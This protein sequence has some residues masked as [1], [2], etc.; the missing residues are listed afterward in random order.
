[1]SRLSMKI[2]TRLMLSF[3]SICFLLLMIFV[4][5][6]AELSKL[7]ADMLLIVRDRWPKVDMAR[8]ILEQTNRTAIA[9]RNMLLVETKDERQKQLDSLLEARKVI[10][11]DI[12]KLESLIVRPKGKALLQ[13]MLQARTTYLA[14][15]DKIIAHIHQGQIAEA[16]AYLRN[17]LPPHLKR[18]KEALDNL[19]QFQV[20]LI[21]ASGRAADEAY[22]QARMLVLVLG[23]SAVVL[24]IVIGWWLAQA[25]TKPLGEAVRLVNSVAEGNLPDKI[26]IRSSDE[27]GRLMQALT[28]MRDSL[29]QVFTR[30]QEVSSDLRVSEASLAEA[31]HMVHLGSW[32]LDP[33]SGRMHWSAETC[34]IFGA[35]H[36][37]E[38]P[39]YENFL[40]R[41]HEHDRKRVR[42]GLEKSIASGNDFNAEHRIVQNHGAVRWVQTIARYGHGDH[43]RLL[44]G[45]IM[46]ITERKH[47]V[48]AL[49][50]SQEL[51]RDLTAHQDRVKE[52]ERKRIARELHDELGQTLLALRIDASMLAARTGDAHPRLNQRARD[53]LEQLD[54]TVKTIRHI[55]NNLRPAVLDLGLAAAIEWQV[56]EFRRR[57]GIACELVVDTEECVL[58]D[59]RA[60]TLFRIL[61]E[62]LTNVIRH[63]KATHVLVE[64]HTEGDRL[65]MRIADNGIGIAADARRPENSFGL[66][67]M[68]ERIHALHGEFQIASTP[69]RGTALT[70]YIPLAAVKEM[71]LAMPSFSTAS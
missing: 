62:S 59:Q 23:L 45:T 6:L 43:H 22:T 58:D 13:Q 31:Q 48:E 60:T 27:T 69:S 7:N 14:G 37:S 38:M 63:A 33:D 16:K 55:I 52:A 2:G 10:A 44:R 34:R 21:E 71:P 39:L 1:M 4:I 46:D 57:S 51:L 65:V 25:I 32:T 26:E 11:N 5:G 53:V 29:G 15:Q 70:L 67:G 9:L 20:E 66:V 50:R 61:Q 18:Y 42:E 24:A 49:K 3:G 8:N 41:V 54:A 35:E 19:I 64:L 30:A 68:E 17:E 47:T 40:N 12:S 28:R 56:N 36:A